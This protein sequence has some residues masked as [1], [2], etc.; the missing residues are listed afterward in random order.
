MPPITSIP[1]SEPST[2]EVMYFISVL[3]HHI[4]KVLHW[5]LNKSSKS[6]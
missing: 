4:I 1:P 6:F 5:G 3:S 2:D